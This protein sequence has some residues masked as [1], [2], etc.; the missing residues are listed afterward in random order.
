MGKKIQ[1]FTEAVLQALS[2]EDR[3]RLANAV[4]EQVRNSSEIRQIVDQFDALKGKDIESTA[5]E[6]DS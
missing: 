3:V 5:A 1:L 4:L 6:E 2:N